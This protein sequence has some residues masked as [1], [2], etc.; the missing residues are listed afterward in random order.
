MPNVIGKGQEEEGPE[1]CEQEI[2]E[3]V[4]EGSGEELGELEAERSDIDDKD[5]LES[6]QTNVR[7]TSQASKNPQNRLKV[8]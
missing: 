3:R 4:E 7:R 8:G 2:V 1:G 5:T 6:S